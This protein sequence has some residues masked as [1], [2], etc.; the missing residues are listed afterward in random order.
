MKKIAILISLIGISLIPCTI[1]ALL[2][3]YSYTVEYFYDHI[4]DDKETIT[5]QA[6]EGD[7]I[8]SYP[9]KRKQGY[10]LFYSTI[11]DEGLTITNKKEYNVIKVFY[12][13]IGDSGDVNP[14]KT[15]VHEKGANVI[16]PAVLI[17]GLFLARKKI[18]N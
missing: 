18:K 15:G 9:E 14:P 10:E 2:N 3:E 1:K 11:D 16:L 17:I 13:K 8:N 5:L 4:L 12:T 7:L 6:N